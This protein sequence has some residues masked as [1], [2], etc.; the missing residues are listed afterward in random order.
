MFEKFKEAL[1]AKDELAETQAK[2]KRIK[3][4][5]VGLDREVAERRKKNAD[6]MQEEIR[7]NKSK[8]KLILEIARLKEDISLAKNQDKKEVSLLKSQI[9][10]LKKET[11]FYKSRVTI[12]SAEATSLTKRVDSLKGEITLLEKENF[13]IYQ[14]IGYLQSDSAEEAM[15]FK[16]ETPK[17]IYNLD[18]IEPQ[19][20]RYYQAFMKDADLKGIRIPEVPRY[21]A[22]I[23]YEDYHNISK[24]DDSKYEEYKEG[25]SEAKWMFREVKVFFDFLTTKEYPIYENLSNFTEL[26]REISWEN[27]YQ[28]E[29]YKYPFIHDLQSENITSTQLIRLFLKNNGINASVD[30]FI[31]KQAAKKLGM[32]LSSEQITKLLKEQRVKLKLEKL[33]QD[34]LAISEEEIPRL[35]KVDFDFLSGIDFEAYVGNVLQKLGFVVNQTKGSGDQGVDLIAVKNEKKYAIQTKRYSQTV[36]NTAIQEAVAGKEHYQADYAWVITNNE[37]TKGALELAES[38]KTLLWNGTK[39][40]EMVEFAEY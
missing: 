36:T 14:S 18:T 9:L 28:E 11:T 7:L 32:D 23:L 13:H 39:L 34:A 37:F 4:S 20:H 2:L 26:F 27:K 5:I 17:S 3:G 33:E 29:L 16:D 8:K 30:Y 40:K 12:L 25:I 15:D 6:S 10:A 1:I 19:L 24:F 21:L 35:S 38:T 31:V 22:K